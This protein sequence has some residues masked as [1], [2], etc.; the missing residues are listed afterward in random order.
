MEVR[1]ELWSDEDEEGT[2]IQSK[3]SIVNNQ[4]NNQGNGSEEKVDGD[5]EAPMP[6]KNKNIF[7]A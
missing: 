7:E 5:D 2:N 3:R 6:M 4:S 1:H